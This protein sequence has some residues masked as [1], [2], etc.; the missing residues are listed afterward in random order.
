[1]ISVDVSGD[2]FKIHDELHHEFWDNKKLNPRVRQALLRIAE[3]FAKYIDAEADIKDVTFTGSMAN[4]NYTPMSDID[5]H[6]VLDYADVDENQEL[7]AKML[8]A[9]KALFNKNHDIKI[10]NYDVELYPQ[11]AKEPHYSTGVY[12][13]TNDEWIAEPVQQEIHVDDGQVIRKGKGIVE[14]TIETIA[15]K[16]ENPEEKINALEKIKE[17]IMKMRKSGLERAGQYSLENLTFKYLR[18]LGI[19]GKIFK[20]INDEFDKMLSLSEGSDY[21]PVVAKSVRVNKRNVP[22]LLGYSKGGSWRPYKK[23]KK[24]KP[25]T[26]KPKPHYL[27]AP[28]GAVGGGSLEE[29]STMSGGD[30]QIYGTKFP[31]PKTY[32]KIAYT[33]YASAVDAATGNKGKFVDAPRAL[34]AKRKNKTIIED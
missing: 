8:R 7:V 2:A 16:S 1:M 31:G 30:V 28:P 5:L 14:K 25:Y 19:L 13:V 11:D 27:S 6:I 26:I 9:K 34:K 20:A 33:G 32:R 3:E 12:S 4:Y 22:I 23:N 18:N 15:L 29:A 21:G 17:K 10:Y 24:F